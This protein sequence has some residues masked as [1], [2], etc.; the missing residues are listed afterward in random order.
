ML[1]MSYVP[2]SSFVTLKWFG[3]FPLRYSDNTVDSIYKVYTIFL[4]M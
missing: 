1:R 4:T 3:G 2:S